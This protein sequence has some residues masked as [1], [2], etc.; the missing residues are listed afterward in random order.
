M[1]H[2]FLPQMIGRIEIGFAILCPVAAMRSIGSGARTLPLEADFLDCSL[3]GDLD[4]V[5]S[6][7]RH[8]EVAK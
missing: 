7:L 4:P 8:N 5:V 1:P 2:G 3:E 6:G